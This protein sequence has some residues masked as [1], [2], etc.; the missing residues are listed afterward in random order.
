MLVKNTADPEQPSSRCKLISYRCQSDLYLHESAE[1][2]PGR[3]LALPTDCYA[4]ALLYDRF[5]KI[6]FSSHVTGVCFIFCNPLLQLPCMSCH[7]SAGMRSSRRTRIGR[8]RQVLR[9]TKTDANLTS[10]R[11]A[12]SIT[13]SKVS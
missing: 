5:A 13:P 8:M 1:Y 6:F 3:G 9:R 12:E 10:K 7:V 4:E 11:M 2:I